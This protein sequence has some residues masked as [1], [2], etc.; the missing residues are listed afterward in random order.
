MGEL[1]LSNIEQLLAKQT[2]QI[3]ENINNNLEVLQEHNNK[4]Q[5]LEQRCLYLE[6]KLRKNNIVIFGLKI[7]GDDLVNQTIT[8]INELFDLHVTTSDFNNIYKIGKG[9]DRPIVVEFVS[10]LKKKEIFSKPEKLRALKGTDISVS[11]DLCQEDRRDQ[12]ILRGHLKTAREK[13]QQA[14]LVGNKLE[15]DKKLYAIR[16]LKEDSASEYESEETPS[17]AD[18]EPQSGTSTADV[19]RRA[20]CVKDGKAKRKASTPSPTI[21]VVSGRRRKKRRN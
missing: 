15:V 10:F 6:R 19:A 2:R 12:K 4:I 16:D 17:D 1:T 5:K 3:N 11:N 7:D 13:G 8:R 21:T 9:T 14:R 20:V 18:H